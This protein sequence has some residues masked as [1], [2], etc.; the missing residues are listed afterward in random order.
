VRI[1]AT[2]EA[3]LANGRLP[4]SEALDDL[5]QSHRVESAEHFSVG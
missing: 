1:E 3:H 4:R 2:V 5:M